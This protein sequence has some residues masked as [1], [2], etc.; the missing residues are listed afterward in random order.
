MELLQVYQKKYGF[1]KRIKLIP[2]LLIYFL[3]IFSCTSDS[4]SENEGN[5]A[6]QGPFQ[7]ATD[8]AVSA[9]TDLIVWTNGNDLLQK[10]EGALSYEYGAA[11]ESETLKTLGINTDSTLATAFIDFKAE[12][13][14]KYRDTN[15]SNNSVGIALVKEI[16]QTSTAIELKA[17]GPGNTYELISSVLAPGSNPIEVPDCGHPEFG[18]HID[19]VF[20]D[21]LNAYVFQFHLH[22]EADDDRC[23][24]FDRQR[25]E[26]KTFDKSPDNLKGLEGETVVYKWKVR[27][28]EG[29]QSSPN[30]THLHQLKAVGATVAST[31]MYTLTTRKSSPDRLELR[32]AENDDQITLKRTDLAP[33]IGVWMEI[34]ETITYGV[35]GA[36][37]IEIRRIDGE[38]LFDYHNTS[39]QNWQP[40]TEFVRPKWGIY[41]SLINAQ[42]L[43]DEIVR[44]TD[45]SIE[46]ITN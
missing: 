8:I 4:E 43:R 44:Y 33:L 34:T 22:T 41:R 40:G 5:M 16:E 12:F 11:Q 1:K 25:N 6:P 27:L 46:E 15:I 39:I 24:N 19:E 31:P 13:L 26:I 30:F 23:I 28:A 37:A 45:F 38:L 14:T 9:S 17:D 3:A 18:R 21:E 42:D 36:Y 20:D 10:I 2:L 29:F 35:Q 32:Y 7:T